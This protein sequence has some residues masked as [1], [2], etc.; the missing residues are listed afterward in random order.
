MGGSS[1]GVHCEIVATCG[2]TGERIAFGIGGGGNGILERLIGGKEPPKYQNLVSSTPGK[3]AEYAASCGK[4]DGG[5]CGCEALACFKRMQ[6]GN[7]PPP[8][9]ALSQ[10]SNSYAH[11]LL[12]QCGCSLSG[13]PPGAVAW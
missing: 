10:N 5:E 2:K 12:G 4:N 7:T 1:G 6:E 11:A 3:V 9:F 13:K 8:Y